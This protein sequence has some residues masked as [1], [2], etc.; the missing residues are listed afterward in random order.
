MNDLWPGECSACGFHGCAECDP[1]IRAAYYYP[2]RQ[3][4]AERFAKAYL[5]ERRMRLVYQ[6]IAA[7][8]AQ[9]ANRLYT[10]ASH[11]IEFAESRVDADRAGTPVS[12]SRVPT[13]TPLPVVGTQTPLVAH[14]QET[15]T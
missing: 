14:D 4:Q 5:E 15:N 9:N 2:R 1:E 11:A 13:T 7:L 12:T 6:G 8:A 10:V 3:R